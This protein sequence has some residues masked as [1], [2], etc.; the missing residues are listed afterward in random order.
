MTTFTVPDKNSLGADFVNK[1]LEVVEALETFISETQVAITAI[2]AS[3]DPSLET[4]ISTEESSSLSADTSQN[5]RLST[6]ESSTLAISPGAPMQNRLIALGAPGAI[7]AG[8]TV[9]IGAD[10][11]EFR[12]DTPP[13]GGTAGRIWVYNGANS[14]A[15]RT[16]LVNAINGV[17]DAA[18][19]TY[20]GAVTETMLAALD[21]VTVGHI[22]LVSADAIGGNPAPSATGTATTETLTTV[23][24]IWDTVT[25]EG[26][27]AQSDRAAAVMQ[28]LTIDADAI[29]AGTK[30]FQFDFTPTQ[31]V[32]VSHNRPQNEAWV[33]V[34]NAVSLTL[35][36]GGSPNN[37]AGDVVTCIAQG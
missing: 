30:E 7:V 2:E 10:V 34:G 19:I 25:V 20:N 6:E 18:T 28:T 24:D 9:T 15:S 5:L 32:I 35:T 23:T 17:I 1:Q 27:Y 3:T 8:D 37:Q 31:A 16:N 22:T 29:T 26:G 33:I 11:Y 14:L 4:R 36:G 13:S 12:G 21:P